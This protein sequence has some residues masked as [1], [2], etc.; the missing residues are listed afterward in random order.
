V[1][2]NGDPIPGATVSIPGTGIGTATDIDGNYSL[3]VP[4]DA[5]LVFSFIGYET[6]TIPV[7]DQSVINVTLVEDISSLDEVVVVGYGTQKKVNLTGSVASIS[8]EDLANMPLPN[9]GE[10]LRGV[11]P[12]LNIS[13][14]GYGG[15]P[16]A[17]RNFNIRGLGSISGDDSP[18]ILVDGV[19]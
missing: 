15:E 10:V 7:G 16:G 18:L 17:E 6:Q 5:S 4:E 11:S 13:L 19:E 3:T 2:E 1:D 9:V 14:S 8:G 12:N